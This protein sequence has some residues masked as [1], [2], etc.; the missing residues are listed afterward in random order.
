MLAFCFLRAR[1]QHLFMSPCPG[2]GLTVNV[3]PLQ[4][5]DVAWRGSSGEVC[6]LRGNPPGE[7]DISWSRESS[8]GVE[9]KQEEGPSIAQVQQ[10]R[11]ANRAE[12]ETAGVMAGPGAFTGLEGHETTIGVN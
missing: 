12:G 8:A 10:G 3:V 1:K 11:C 2:S 6:G 9:W 5:G 7:D 4:W